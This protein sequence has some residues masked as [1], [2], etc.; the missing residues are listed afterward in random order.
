VPCLIWNG[1]FLS[2]DWRDDN[3]ACSALGLQQSLEQRALIH[4]FSE[5]RNDN[6]QEERGGD[7]AF[8]MD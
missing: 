3:I 5:G 1:S 6:R 4:L 8:E 7:K 2:L